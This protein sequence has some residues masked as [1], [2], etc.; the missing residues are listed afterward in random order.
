MTLQSFIKE[1][2]HSPFSLYNLPYGIFKPQNEDSF[3][4]GVAIG[5]WVLDL[6]FLEKNT[7]FL[8]LGKKNHLQNLF[9]QDRLNPFAAQ[10]PQVWHAVRQQVQQLLSSDNPILQNHPE[11]YS[12]IL[13]PQNQVTL[14]NPFHTHAFTDFYASQHHASN[15]GI[16]FR[17]KENPLLPNWKYLPVGYH[18]RAS[19]LYSSGELIRRPRGQVKYP[20]S[21]EPIFT[22]TQKLDFELEMGCFIGVGNPSGEPISIEQAS[23]HLFG[24]VL[25]NDWSARDIQAFE[26]QPLGPFLSKSFA[27]SISPWVVPMEALQ[28]YLSTLPEQTPKPVSYLQ[29]KNRTLPSIRLTVE[30][31][32]QNSKIHTKI[33]ETNLTEIYWS[34]EQMLAHHTV[35]R[36]IMQTGDLFA[37]GTISGSNSSAW[38]SLL[39]LSHNGTVPISL[40]D[41]NQRCFLE[42]GDSIIIQGFCEKEGLPPIGFGTLIN[43]VSME[44]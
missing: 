13:F 44:N 12:R 20:N 40:L 19:T 41:G 2:N 14:K 24:M 3:R 36:C 17:G 15:V 35:N 9:N 11:L 4:V 37:T 10:G 21:E 28:P 5:D 6:S 18:G 33:C 1:A 26:Y 30:I 39:E 43:T 8:D 34:L 27:T 38:G 31:Q 7:L 16:L 29:Q 32:P 22:P 23:Q 25:L 42:N